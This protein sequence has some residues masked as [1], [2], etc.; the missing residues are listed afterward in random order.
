MALWGNKDQFSDAPKFVTDSATGETGQEEYGN[1]VFAVD[2]QEVA[3]GD[4]PHSGWVRRVEGTGG[5]AGRVQEEV[6]CAMSGATFSKDG[7]DF[8]D[9][10]DFANTD[11]EAVANG[12]ADDVEYPDA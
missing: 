8:L 5:R 10:A 11:A 1:Q 7:A 3:A 2:A 4:T 12:A 6:L 9:A